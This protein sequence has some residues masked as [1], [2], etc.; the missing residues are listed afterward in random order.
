MEN[1]SG[2]VAVLTGAASGIGEGAAAALAKAGAKIVVA[3]LNIAGAEAVAAGIAAKGGEALAVRCDVGLDGEFENL[4]DR[5]LERFG[6]VDIVMNNAGV[7]LSGL[8]E[9][10]P[11]GEWARVLNINL[12]SVVRSNAVFLPIFL[13]QG[14]GH[15]VNTS[16]FA[17]LYTYAFDRLPYAASK[18]AIFSM[19]EGLALY[20]RPKNIGVTV[21]CPGPVRTNIMSS[22]K[23]FSKDI[24][25]RGPGAEFNL[26]TAE[27]V[28]ALV[29]DA[30]QRN[31]F[32]LPT[33]PQ[34]RERLVRRAQDFNANL[35]DQ[36][37]HP[38]IIEPP[39]VQK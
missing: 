19:S 9:D 15:I 25:I 18:A 5:T 7:I 13:Q 30:I 6:A 11:P 22:A 39:P 34:V 17:G 3:D 10:V 4:R 32:F 20:L 36:I 1:I 29:V 21:L 16:S 23:V 28:G 38:Q 8:P 12:M 33:H 37:D 26:M 27:Q 2:R 35:Q 14:A 31:I 24:K